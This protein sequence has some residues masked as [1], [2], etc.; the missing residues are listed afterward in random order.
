MRRHAPIIKGFLGSDK[1]FLKGTLLKYCTNNGR[2]DE[3]WAVYLLYANANLRIGLT[4]KEKK[5]VRNIKNYINKQCWGFDDASMSNFIFFP[6]L[7][8]NLTPDGAI[9]V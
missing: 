8:I 7:W 1:V 3:T 5:S 6:S 4:W 9:H 2:E